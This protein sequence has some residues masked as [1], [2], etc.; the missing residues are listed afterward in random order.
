[1]VFRWKCFSLPFLEDATF[2]IGEARRGI[3]IRLCVSWSGINCV[4]CALFL[5]KFERNGFHPDSAPMTYL[6]LH[7]E[8]CEQK[9]LNFFL[10]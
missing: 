5:W 2:D 10:W 7:K 6:N 8:I 4:V 1:M 3:K 9:M